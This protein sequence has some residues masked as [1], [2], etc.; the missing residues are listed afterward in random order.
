MSIVFL[1]LFCLIPLG[2]AK[3]EFIEKVNTAIGDCC[4]Q[5]NEQSGFSNDLYI[6]CLQGKYE[7]C[8]ECKLQKE[9]GITQ[10]NI[11]EE[12]RKEPFIA[13]DC[14]DDTVN[15]KFKVWSSIAALL[16]QCLDKKIR[17]EVEECCQIVDETDNDNF[18]QNFNQCL[19]DNYSKEDIDDIF[20][21]GEFNPGDCDAE[22]EA[23]ISKVK[24][25]KQRLLIKCIKNKIDKK[26]D[27][28]CSESSED[29]SSTNEDFHQKFMEC[30]KKN[31]AE[32]G[33]CKKIISKCKLNETAIEEAVK[34]YKVEAKDCQDEK[35][36]I[37][38]KLMKHGR[39]I[40]QKCK[41]NIERERKE[42][43]E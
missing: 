1:I 26:I 21:N 24:K 15:A 6:E 25:Q 30:L 2:T 28:C 39:I 14:Q 11:F 27:E 37:F 19:K 31:Y 7:E 40:F 43:S 41:E 13:K 32:C 23:T 4:S 12:L 10:E 16:R 9:C 29:A 36:I 22:N 34:E 42:N 8:E 18:Q 17:Q 5:Q 38:E 3:L 20:N 33:V 35:K